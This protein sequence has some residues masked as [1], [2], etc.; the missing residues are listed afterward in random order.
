[1]ETNEKELTG[2]QSIGAVCEKKTHL[3]SN[4]K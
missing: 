1:M 4:P 2:Y 3:L